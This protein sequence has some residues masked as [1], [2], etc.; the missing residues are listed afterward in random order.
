MNTSNPLERLKVHLREGTQPDEELLEHL[1]NSRESFRALVDELTPP[2]TRGPSVKTR[3]G[4]TVSERASKFAD[5]AEQQ[6]R[7]HLEQD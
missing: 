3:G 6:L 1:A 4:A 7:Q 5:L 2:K